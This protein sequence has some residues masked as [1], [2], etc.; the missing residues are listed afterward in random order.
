MMMRA[1][2]DVPDNR[3][4]GVVAVQVAVVMSVLLGCAAL[5]VD[6]GYIYNCRGEMQSVV[7]AS[8]LAGAS[9]LPDSIGVANH[10]ALEYAGRNAV[11]GSPLSVDETGVTIGYWNSASATFTPANGAELVSPNA[12]RVVGTRSGVELFFAGILG[13]T[14]TE[15]SKVASALHGGGKCTGIWGIEGITGSGGIITDSFDAEAGPYGPGN[16]NAYG[17]I[18]SCQDIMLEGSVNIYGDAMYGND[19]S[20]T[21]LGSSY[22]IWG[23]VDSTNCGLTL[24]SFDINE[25]AANNDN[26]TIGLTDR[27]RDPFQGSPWDLYV[28]GNDNLTLGAGT[29]YFTSVLID[30]Q[31]TLTVTG[32]VKIYL[33]GPGV[34]TG[35]GVVN[36][37]QEPSDVQI[38]STGATL[39]LTGTSGFYG[40]VIAPT[41][42]IKL[43]GTSDCYG[44][45][46]GRTLDFDGDTVVHIDESLVRDLLGE[47][48]LAPVLVE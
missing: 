2:Q 22:N 7:D 13:V 28:T 19:Y 46:I 33:S 41:T 30:G 37:G 17:D 25:V 9:G 34:F 4:R 40:A 8:A 23:A 36:V 1:R 48:T 47:D 16:T 14:S 42:D 10:R 26:A 35:G 38:F 31:A 21:T 27:G 12:V 5:T 6:V 29:Y 45:L 15:V 20:L 3:H 24:P 18:C 43:E 32:P 44:T 11:A 39:T